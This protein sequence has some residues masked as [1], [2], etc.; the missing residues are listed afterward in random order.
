MITLEDVADLCPLGREEIA[1]LAEHEH[2]DG[3][4]AVALA[5]YL[6]HLPKGPQTVNRMICE[7][8]REALHRDDVAH[9]RELFAALRQFMADHP[10]AARG[11]EG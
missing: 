11:A 1:A 10:E 9:A 3:L 7:D 2:V 6:M 4:A 8:I 5:N